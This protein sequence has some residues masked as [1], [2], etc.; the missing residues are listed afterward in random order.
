MPGYTWYDDDGNEVVEFE[1]PSQK[2]INEQDTPFL[3]ACLML[4]SRVSR[5]GNPHGGGW[6]QERSTVIEICEIVES[7]KNRYQSW[8]FKHS[9]DLDDRKDD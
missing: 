7:E 1:Y 9:K 3:R 5:F 2:Q 8:S 4:A 6:L